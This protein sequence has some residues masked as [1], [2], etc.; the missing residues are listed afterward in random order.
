MIRC[1]VRYGAGLAVYGAHAGLLG[2]LLLCQIWPYLYQERRRCAPPL[3]RR[4][5]R[6]LP[7]ETSQ[8][9]ALSSCAGI[10]PGVVPG[11][12][13]LLIVEGPGLEAAVQDADEAVGE[14]AERGL[15]FDV[16]AAELVVV[17]PCAR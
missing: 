9:L 2:N 17:G 8:G 1:A 11:P 3:A 6:A 14:L 16:A 7:W 10:L 4:Q 12:G 5:R 13:G 15:V